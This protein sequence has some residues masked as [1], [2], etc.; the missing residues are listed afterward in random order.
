MVNNQLLDYVKQQFAQGISREQIHNNLISAGGWNSA[1]IDEVFSSIDIGNVPYAMPIV[2]V[3]YAGFWIRFVATIVDSLILSIPFVIARFG[4]GIIFTS[5][6]LSTKIL[7][8]IGL[9]ASMLIGWIYFILMTHNKGATLGKMLV[10]ITVKSD[11]FQKLS[12]GKV[13]LRETIGKFVSGIILYIGYIIAGFTKRK[14][15]LHDKFAHS[16][17]V[18]KDPSKSHRTGLILGII[19][20]AILP[21]IAMVGILSS[22]VLASLN[23]ARQKSQDMQI[24]ANISQMRVMVEVYYIEN[25]NSYSN[26][27]NCYSGIFSSQN[28]QQIVSDMAGK[29][30]T[31]YAEGSSYA[32]SAKLK[33]SDQ[34]YCVDSFN[35]KGNGIANNNG[36]K[37]FCSTGA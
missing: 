32:I 29:N 7:A 9:L 20:A 28:M 36:S 31:C 35:Y 2:T 10:G 13:I 25:N 17:V 14:Q 15:A 37:A 22:V 24:I 19:I 27:D 4:V 16:V 26:A 23:V 8:I 5:S 33:E 3:K 18:Y 1:D 30:L 6:G 34:N 11:D 21:V 12:L